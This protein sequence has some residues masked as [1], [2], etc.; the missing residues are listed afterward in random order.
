MDYQGK[1]FP[2]ERDE[3]ESKIYRTVK[4]IFKWTMYGISFLI[5]A[6][7]FYILI[8]NRDSKILEKNYFAELL[9]SETQKE[10]LELYRINTRIFMNDD[11]SLQILDADYSDEHNII[12]IG[13][14]YNA[15]K[16]TNGSTDNA[17]AYKLYDKDGNVYTLSKTVFDDHGRYGFAKLCFTGIDIDLDV[18]IIHSVFPPD[19]FL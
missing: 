6:I 19:Q 8:S 18:F 10:S 5:Y 3:N 17:L 4:G 14:K 15:K 1:Y 7:I 2:D 9:P 13:V 12:E 11:G 16:L